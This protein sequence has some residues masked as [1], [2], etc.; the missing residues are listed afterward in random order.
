MEER[1]V[2]AGAAKESNMIYVIATVELVPGQ[3]EVFLSEFRRLVPQVR[4]E[5]GCLEYQP[6]LDLRADIPVQPPTR[7]N[8]LTVIEKW[9]SLAA[10]KQHLSAP[11]MQEYRAR[12]KDM[13]A[14]VE[15]RVLQPA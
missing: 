4:A 6:T 2:A 5:Q 9:E 14:K 8:V 12:V 15:L 1:V 7:E 10:L 13:V 11:H 3:R